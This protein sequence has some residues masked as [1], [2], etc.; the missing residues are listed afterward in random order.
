MPKPLSVLRRP[1]RHAI[2]LDTELRRDLDRV[3]QSWKVPVSVVIYWLLKGLMADSRGEKF[4]IAGDSDS[5]RLARWL[6]RKFPPLN[7]CPLQHLHPRYR[8]GME[9]Q[10][11]ND[12]KWRKAAKRYAESPQVE[13][14]S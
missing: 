13:R 9:P 4:A 7:P 1:H 14:K 2:S 12:P 6:M 8:P 3:A 11:M 10:S 5:E